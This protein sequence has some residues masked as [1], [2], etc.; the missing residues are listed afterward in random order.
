[1]TGVFG[2]LKADEGFI[3]FYCDILEPRMKSGAKLGQMDLDKITR[4]FQI[5]VRMTSTEFIKIANWM[6]GHIKE[7]EK[8]GIVKVEKKPRK[9]VEAYRV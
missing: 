3:K 6:A 5:E 4:E 9:D 2:A 8:R 7:L 1:V